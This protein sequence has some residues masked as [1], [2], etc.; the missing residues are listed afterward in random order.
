MGERRYSSY[1]FL[2]LALDGGEWSASRTGRA[3]PPGKGPL[4]HIEQEA[5]WAP[6]PVWTQR[7]EEKF[8]A[9]VGD[10]T[11][12]VQSVVRHN[13][14]WATPAPESSNSTQNIQTCLCDFPYF[15]GH[16]RCLLQKPINC[17]NGNH[18]TQ[19]QKLFY[20]ILSNIHP[21]QKY[22]YVVDLNEVYILLHILNCCTLYFVTCLWFCFFLKSWTNP[23]DALKGNC[24]F[25][26]FHVE[27]PTA[28]L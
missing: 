10:R 25:S 3:L 16:E 23:A 4:V 2:I 27:K 19:G 1:S 14:D 20:C 8:S 15:I 11:L 5:G 21:I 9:S 24:L 12:V 28:L 6:E 22:V 13:T 7:L 17:Y 26:T 18:T